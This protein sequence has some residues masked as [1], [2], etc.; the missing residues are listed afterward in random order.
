MAG[1]YEMDSACHAQSLPLATSYSH[2]R[3]LGPSWRKTDLLDMCKDSFG[4]FWK[5]GSLLSYHL[6]LWVLSTPSSRVV[7]VCVLSS[8]PGSV[9]LCVHGE[10]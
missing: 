4:E 5:F 8:G 10:V 3:H 9:D 7:E 2:G 6:L 1:G